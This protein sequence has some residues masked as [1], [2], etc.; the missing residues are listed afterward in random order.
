MPSNDERPERYSYPETAASIFDPVV[1]KAR[2]ESSLFTCRMMDL[3]NQRKAAEPRKVT[4][5]ETL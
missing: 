1:R 3:A 2:E 4:G 5:F